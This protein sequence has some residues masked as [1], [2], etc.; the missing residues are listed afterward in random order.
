MFSPEEI[1]KSLRDLADYGCDVGFGGII[2]VGTLKRHV[3]RIQIDGH[4]V[5][6]DDTVRMAF[7]TRSRNCLLQ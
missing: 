6:L 3:L 4:W 7:E 1:D 5:D 2:A